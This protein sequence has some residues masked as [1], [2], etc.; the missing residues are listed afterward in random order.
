MVLTILLCD[1][2]LSEGQ[3]IITMR[4]AEVE[5]RSTVALNDVPTTPCIAAVAGVVDDDSHRKP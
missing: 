2:L 3:M 4:M 1:K 5:L